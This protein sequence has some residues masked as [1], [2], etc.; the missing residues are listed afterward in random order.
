MRLVGREA[1]TAR[2]RAVA[3]GVREHGGALVL[4]GAAGAGKS[5]LLSEAAEY[6]A[7]G[8]VRVLSVSGVESETRLP[9]AGLQRLLYPLRAAAE[10]LPVADRE[11]LRAA[12]GGADPAVP[13]GYRVAL[14]VLDL[15]V[16]VARQ[17][18]VLLIAE[19]A[20]WL[21]DRTTEVLVLLARRLE[22]ERVV[23]LAAVRDG[24]DARLDAAGLP[25]LAVAP[26]TEEAAAALL[27]RHSPG[28]EP[29]SRER[30]LAAAAGNPLALTELP[31]AW[32]GLERPDEGAFLSEPWLPLTARLERAFTGRFAAL[33]APTRALL[34][35]AALNDGASLAETLAA[36]R[37]AT[38]DRPGEEPDDRPGVE[39][40]VPAVGAL[41]V[42]TDGVE[43]R[44]RHPL[45]RSAIRQGMTL[46]ERRAAHAALADVLAGQQDRRSRHRAAAA[47]PPDETVAAELQAS[48]ARAERRGATGA[49]V[50]ALEQAARFSEDPVLRA[51]RL[52]LAADFA[53]E[54]GRREVV[55]RLLAEASQVEL[56]PQQRARVVWIG[57]SFDEGLRNPTADAGTLA[58]L[59]ATVAAAGDTYLAVRVLWS[60]A[61]LCYWSE[62]GAGA[63]RFVVRVAEGMDL[64]ELDPWLLA[65]LA[66]AA[67]IERGAVVIERLRR[68][69]PSPYD[70]AR[71]DRML[72][73]AALLVGSYDLAQ[74]LSAA[75]ATGLRRQGRRGLL[76]RAVGAEASSAALLGDLATA[77]PAAAESGRLAHE[78]TQPYLYGLMRAVEAAVAALRGDRDRAAALA[79]EAEQAGL[80][81]GAR[82]VLA[83]AQLARGLAALGAGEFA[84]AYA[85]LRR[86]HDSAD[87]C[88]HLALR[89]YAVGDL[90]DA[91]V[92]C[93]RGAE[94]SGIMREMEAVGLAT[95]S[96]ALHAGL[97]FARA[98]LAADDEA[99][100]LFA[101]AL[102]ADLTRWPFA[103]ARAQLAF[104]EWL[105]RQRRAAD[106]RAP[107]RAAREAFDALG[108]IPWSER[109]RQEMRASGEGS[110]RRRPEEQAR[111]TPQELRIAR[112]AAEGL[113]NREIGQ[114][115]Y[116][117]HRTVSSH[118]HRIFPKLGV[119][120]RAELSMAVRPLA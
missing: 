83:R 11:V 86:L 105:R 14:T 39:D 71:T 22:C 76:A 10:L 113:T 7:A 1:E 27:D 55:A 98:L 114:K 120:S 95:P 46:P 45:T 20:H 58:A 8:G 81:V 16:G 47:P 3:D 102:A 13:D 89:C 67:P 18:P 51:E 62:P 73:T 88:Y 60:A 48:A 41:L 115:L 12:L 94:I 100:E 97:R 68:R 64:D 93:G 25:E 91:A 92:H 117:S 15:L 21:D 31:G 109:A 26:L 9:F 69:G 111:L 38:G 90:A 107:L 34:R 37:R 106:S 84:E 72:G 116:L 24:Y 57:G 28:L 43:L 33:P 40:L 74:S 36:A 108:A 32:A 56:S 6:A 119:A 59:A 104:G 66:Y 2:L 99:E 44:F 80:P 82:P 23:L 29:E 54:L 5:A 110:R 79:A 61:Q 30:L 19:D 49:A 103:R 112:M 65:I 53:V 118:L 75:A 78:T 87:P 4:R 70:D 52:L 50:A 17:A 63:R 101:E 96:P 85:Q 42:E 77:V 35:I